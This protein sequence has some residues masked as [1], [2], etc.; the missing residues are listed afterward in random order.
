MCIFCATTTRL[1]CKTIMIILKLF[2]RTLPLSAIG[3]PNRQPHPNS[4]YWLDWMLKQTAILQYHHRATMFTLLREPN[5]LLDLYLSLNI[6]LGY[7]KIFQITKNHNLQLLSSGI[8][9]MLICVE[10]IVK[11]N[12]HCILQLS[13]FK[14]FKSICM[15]KC[16]PA[17]K[18]ESLSHYKAFFSISVLQRVI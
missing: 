18:E 5:H 4:L 13:L 17:L 7:G 12:F 6:K 10:T 16:F 14:S 9:K 2:S 8:R 15:Q 3:G 1:K 11:L